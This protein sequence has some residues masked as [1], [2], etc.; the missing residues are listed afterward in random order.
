MSEVAA[1]PK[2]GNK[3]KLMIIAVASVLLVAA[4]GGG[5]FV[6][7]TGEKEAP[8]EKEEVVEAGPPAFVE[9][10]PMM[11]NLNSSSGPRYLRLRLLLELENA[12]SVP[13]AEIVLPRIV[14]ALQTYLRQLNPDELNGSAGPQKLQAEL[15]G[16]V[17]SIDHH[18]PVTGI[19]VQELLVQ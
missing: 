3:K 9:I 7:L 14:D 17:N 1:Q 4:I 5:A 11:V 2:S 12:E 16:V 18:L 13:A 10:P 15:I 6:F 8:V 19:L